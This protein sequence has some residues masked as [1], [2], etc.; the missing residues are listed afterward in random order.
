MTLPAYRRLPHTAD[1]RLV[2]WG[3]GFEE[4]CRNA[5]RGTLHEA[6][7]RAPRG[8]PT[9]YIEVGEAEDDD[10]L[11]LVRT[12]NEALFQLYSRRLVSTDL[13][14]D[15]QRAALGVRELPHTSSP[16]VEVKAATLHDLAASTS[17]G[18][19]CIVL[20]LDL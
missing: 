12:V 5:V 4:L 14:F 6:L 3:A 19:T 8:T 17:G 13:R 7:G 16:E 18:R 15:G 10:I 11:W 20:T 9:H 2:V 1:L